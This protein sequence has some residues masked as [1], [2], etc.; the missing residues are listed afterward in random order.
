M[1]ELGH[2]AFMM[3]GD[4]NP[5]VSR[6]PTLPLL[7]ILACLAALGTFSTNIL[8]ASLP[9]IAASFSVPTTA[10]G[11]M[12]SSFFATFAVGQLV[13]G[14]L[15]DRYGR[16]PVV[17]V[18]L[19][20]FVA[21]SALCAAATTLPVIVAGRVV[22]AIG[23]C[24]SSVLSRA[25]A[26]DLFSGAELARVLSF[27]MVA[28][29][30]AP[31]F[32]PLLGS[33]LDHAFG[34]R[35]TFVAVALFGLVLSFAY[36]AS[37][38]ETHH[39]ERGAFRPAEILSGYRALLDDRRFIVPA[40]SVSMVIGGLFAVFT[41]TPAILVDGLGFSPL[42]LSLFYAGTVFVVFGAGLL[43]PRLAQRYGLAAVTRYGLIIA[44]AGC[45]L[46]AILVLAGFRNFAS[47]LIPM[48]VFLF[49]MGMANPIGTALAL[50]HFGERAGAASALLGF[51]QMAF[52][53]AAIVAATTLPLTAFVALSLV[54]ASLTTTGLLI[55]F[56]Q[57]RLSGIAGPLGAQPS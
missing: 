24:A 55:F 8:L 39:G 38:G 26:R 46:M 32:S 54:L 19:I 11:S 41:V 50:S 36:S 48:L 27:V 2:D 40:A 16:R 4:T 56:F 10:T 53:A 23:V 17:L 44:C 22:Q 5:S 29:A 47:Y 51:L 52:A 28:M 33:G 35:S 1:N 20:V 12:M 49:G 13:V 7:A 37:V 30:A 15:A 34:W 14:P 31:G 45:V 25:I 57:A 6:R 9:G 3:S 42:S 43:A 21:G 18:G